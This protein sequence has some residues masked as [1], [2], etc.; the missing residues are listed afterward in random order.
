MQGLSGAQLWY[1][2][3]FL[4]CEASVNLGITEGKISSQYGPETI[5]FLEGGAG[6]G[7]GEVEIIRFAHRFHS[8]HPELSYTHTS[9]GCVTQQRQKIIEQISKTCKASRDSINLLL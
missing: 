1:E 5:N 2:N 4:L 3:N 6:G 7:G 8:L 9:D